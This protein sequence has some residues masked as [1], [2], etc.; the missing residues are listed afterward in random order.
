MATGLRW[1]LTDELKFGEGLWDPSQHARPQRGED[2]FGDADFEAADFA[3]EGGEGDLGKH[4]Y[5]FL[6]SNIVVQLLF[7]ISRYLLEEVLIIGL[8]ALS[9]LILTSHRVKYGRSKSLRECLQANLSNVD[10]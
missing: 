5:S 1:A 2:G 6:E 10:G 9:S 8:G 7:E 4:I 3:F